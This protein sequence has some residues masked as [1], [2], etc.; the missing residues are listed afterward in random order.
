MDIKINDII[1]KRDEENKVVEAYN[2]EDIYVD[3]DKNGYNTMIVI[4]TGGCDKTVLSLSDLK[5]KLEYEGY[6]IEQRGCRTSI[7]SENTF[8]LK[9]TVI[10][11][12]KN[13]YSWKIIPRTVI[14]PDD[15]MIARAV[16]QFP[17]GD[18]CSL[19][20]PICRDRD[21]SMETFLERFME[22]ISDDPERFHKS[23]FSLKED[24]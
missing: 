19:N 1:L 8:G 9:S 2:I 3:K 5:Q 7:F 18:D 13:G 23:G 22:R 15:I 24:Y 17:S 4:M 6:V 14:I 21:K 11:Q 12:S 16:I 10:S 20:I